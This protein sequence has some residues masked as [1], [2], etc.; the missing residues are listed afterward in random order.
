[1]MDKEEYLTK[2]GPTEKNN[3]QFQSII[4]SFFGKTL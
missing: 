4:K 2:I 3:F 1:M